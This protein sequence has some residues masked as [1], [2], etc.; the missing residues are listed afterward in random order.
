MVIDYT[1]SSSTSFPETTH[2]T[3][4]KTFLPNR[5]RKLSHHHFSLTQDYTKDFLS[6]LISSHGPQKLLSSPLL[7]TPGPGKGHSPALLTM[8]ALNI[9][10]LPLYLTH[11]LV[12]YRT[13]SSSTPQIK[14]ITSNVLPTSCPT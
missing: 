8:R 9:S 6:L 1:K 7:L 13:A 11:V 4:T 3:M 2:P 14:S 10:S 5:V 12:S